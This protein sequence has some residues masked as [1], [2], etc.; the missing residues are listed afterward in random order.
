VSST[1]PNC[2]AALPRLRVGDVLH[3]FCHGLF[4]RDSYGEKTVLA[5]GPDWVLVSEQFQRGRW[6]DYEEVRV[7]HTYSGNP[8]DLL[9]YL[10]PEPEQD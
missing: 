9:E 2:G 10:T 8:D 7:L 4:G 3:G 1:C 6:P 5:I